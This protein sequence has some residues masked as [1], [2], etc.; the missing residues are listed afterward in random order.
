MKLPLNEKDKW[1]DSLVSNIVTSPS[2]RCFFVKFLPFENGCFI[3]VSEG[4]NRI[5]GMYVSISSSNKIDT[6]KVIPS[7]YDSMFIS[8][9]SQRV[10]SLINGIC[11]VCIHGLEKLQLDDMKSIMEKIISMVEESNEKDLGK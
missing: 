2:N 7:K 4:S 10:A 1:S 11:I 5:G 8:T 3:I 9:L 6:A